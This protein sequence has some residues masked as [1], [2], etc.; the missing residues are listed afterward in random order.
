M[1][2]SKIRKKINTG[3]EAFREDGL[4]G[5]SIKTLEFLQKTQRKKGKQ[6][7]KLQIDTTAI[8]D[9]VLAADPSNPANASWKSPTTRKDSLRVTWLMPPPGKG[10]GG[11]M[12]LFRFIK[13]FEEAGHECRIYLHNPGKGSTIEAVYELMGDGFPT[14]KAKDTMRWLD[15]RDE[16]E[17]CDVL[18]A[19]SWQTAYTVYKSKV[20]AKKFYFVQDFEP[21]FYPVG[22]HS[23][24]AE[25]TYKLGLRGITAGGWLSNRLSTEYGM[26]A[27]PFDFGSDSGTYTLS[28][29]GP[30]KEIVFYARPTTARRAF[31]VGVLTLD[32]FHRMHPEYVINFIGWDISEYNIPFPHKNLGILSP[33]ELNELYNKC[34]ASLVMS[35][36][37]MSLLP[38][39][40]LSSGCIPVVTDG[41]NNRLVSN[42]PFI[43]YAEKDPVSLAKALAEIVE[44]DDLPSYAKLASASV[45]NCN[46]DESGKKVVNAVEEAYHTDGNG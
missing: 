17:E 23:I 10:S 2:I 21:Y 32:V 31:E 28:N 40:L 44:H 3:Y 41:D 11:H 12:T 37:N 5:L 8:Y 43:K 42:D 22:G 25:N 1:M 15:P 36:T 9:E 38:L 24:L 19:T 4:T 27:T 45:K 20:N 26:T 39:E 16:M 30:R 35:L 46:W 13:Y 29:T 18:F 7:F 6:K 34:A 33:N 14:V